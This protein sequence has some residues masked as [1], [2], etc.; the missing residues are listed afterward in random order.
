MD[1]VEDKRSCQMVFM[2]DALDVVFVQVSMMDNDK[3]K[4]IRQLL[5]L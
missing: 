2:G 5:H 1:I 3:M 4:M